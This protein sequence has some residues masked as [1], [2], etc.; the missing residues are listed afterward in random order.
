MC[1]HFYI[2]KSLA[3]L[4]TLVLNSVFLCLLILEFLIG[5]SENLLCSLSVLQAKIFLMLDALQ[6][7]MLSARALTYLE[8]KF[9]PLII[10]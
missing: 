5:I 1:L 8:S 9:F 4:I 2:H 6:L 10:L 3:R 7:L